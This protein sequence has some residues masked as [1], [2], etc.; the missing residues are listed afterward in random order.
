MSSSQFDEALNKYYQLK[1]KY[2]K[3]IQKFVDK[4]RTTPNLSRN[5]KHQKFIEF[6]K[7]CINCG[8]D[9]GSIFIQ[10]GN[11]LVAR[12]GHVEKP[13][14]LNIKLQRARYT[15]I[16]K[17]MLQQAIEIN[18]KKTEI[19][20]TKLNFL[21]GFVNEATTLV[22]FNKLKEELVND[23]KSYQKFINLYMNIIQNAQNKEE[24]NKLNSAKLSLIHSF[25]DLI[26]EFEKTGT[27]SYL[28]DAA[29]LYVNQLTKLVN[30]IQPLKYK[31]QYVYLENDEKHILV[32]D[33]YTPS[34]LQV[35]IP[36]TENKILAFTI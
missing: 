28:K 14:N 17:E 32:Q 5:E 11:I 29:E 34:Q 21:F 20:K 35:I 31:V 12:C 3:S 1:N 23:V 6:K 26:S 10:D 15:N 25:K 7:K 30:E 19:I 8:K 22:D 4:L 13:C 36:G 16:T 2:D 24:I 9:G 27:I 33:T 18:N